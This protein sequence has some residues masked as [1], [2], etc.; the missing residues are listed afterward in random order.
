[1]REMCAIAAILSALMFWLIDG[2]VGGFGGSSALPSPDL[3]SDLPIQP[4]AQK[5]IVPVPLPDSLGIDDQLW[6]NSAQ[7][8]RRA[9]LVAIDH[10]LRY[11]ST[12]KAIESYRKYPVLG[13]SRDRVQRSL[14]R[15]RQLLVM[16]RSA[17]DLQAAV[18]REFTFYQAIGN[19]GQ[20]TV[21]FTGYFEPVHSASRVPTREFRYPIFRLPANWSAW[22]KP[23]PTRLQLEGEDGLQFAKSPL[24]GLEL[25]WL[26]DRLDAFLIQVQGSARLKLTDSRTISVGYSGHTDYPYTSIGRELVNAG[27]IPQEKL[28]LPAVIQYFKHYPADLNVYLPRNRRFVFFQETGGAPAMGSLGV[29]V[30]P[31]RSIAT[32]KTQFPPGALALIQTQIPD[33]TATGKLQQRPV[34]RYMLDQDTGGAI[35][36]S[37]RVD[38]FMGTG[39][40]AGDRAGLINSTGQLYY[41]LIKK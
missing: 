16:A 17:Q 14:K 32:D 26:R 19:D 10:S 33:S 23:Q 28:S 21:A 7:G 3:V 2:P 27:K 30:T 6:G 35:K 4:A 22:S 29:P 25:V 39:K 13:V 9:L 12:A 41:L 20:G 36:G 5:S 38:I 8:N 18:E 40:L 15:F 11:L 34:N 24:K 37:G 31:E 1:M